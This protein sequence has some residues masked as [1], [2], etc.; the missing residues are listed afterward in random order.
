MVDTM[1][2]YVTPIFTKLVVFKIILRQHTAYLVQ[3][4]WFK[5]H[6]KNIY[7]CEI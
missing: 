4:E 3:Y 1:L 6:S 2:H 5:R 7:L